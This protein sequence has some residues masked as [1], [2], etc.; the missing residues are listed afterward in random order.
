[1]HLVTEVPFGVPCQ[2]RLW[3]SD[4]VTDGVAEA[5]SKRV[6][7]KG[8]VMKNLKRF[9]QNGLWNYDRGKG[10][11]VRHEWDQVYRIRPTHSKFRIIGFYKDSTR[12]DFIAIDAFTKR[13]DKLSEPETG[14]VNEVVR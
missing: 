7:P 6:D 8:I 9:S 13:S 2:T 1:M 12:A 4:V 14:R 3:F 5:A 11:P 10:S